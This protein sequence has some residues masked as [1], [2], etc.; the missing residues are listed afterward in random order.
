M[1]APD[2]APELKK[3]ID[4]WNK[5][6]ATLPPETQSQLDGLRQPWEKPKPP[7]TGDNEFFA[8]LPA[9]TRNALQGRPVSPPVNADMGEVLFGLVE[10]RDGEYPLMRIFR[11]AEDLARHLGTLEGEDVAVWAYYG[12]AMPFTAGPMRYLYLPDNQHAL[13]VP[14]YEGGPVRKVRTD[15]LS[16]A[17]QEDGFLGPPELAEIHGVTSLPDAVKKVKP[18]PSPDKPTGRGDGDSNAPARE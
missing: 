17:M 18:K 15:I 6:A 13:T 5:W 9:E 3:K 7:E 12:I 16:L 4:R 2:P 14:T 8:S 11:R 1:A 10:C